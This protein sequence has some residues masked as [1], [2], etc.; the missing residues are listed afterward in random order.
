MLSGPYG[1]TAVASARSLEMIDHTF[2]YSRLSDREDR[3]AID[4]RRSFVTSPMLNTQLIFSK[5]LS[6]VLVMSSGGKHFVVKAFYSNWI[7]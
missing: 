5:I 1:A 3:A 4:C 2:A 6:M 7:C